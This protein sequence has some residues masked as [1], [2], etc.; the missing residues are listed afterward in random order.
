ME[1]KTVQ[2]IQNT[3]NAQILIMHAKID[4]IADAVLSLVALQK[5]ENF[6]EVAK[7]F[8]KKVS[9]YGTFHH[10]KVFEKTD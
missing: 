10:S 9:E 8:T 1:E 6:D 3:I 7:T 4:A 2:E 5:G